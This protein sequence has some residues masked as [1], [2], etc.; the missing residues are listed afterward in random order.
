MEPFVQPTI[1]NSLQ[2]TH[3]SVKELSRVEG[4]KGY[5]FR[6]IYLCLDWRT[7]HS[8]TTELKTG[9][10]GQRTNHNIHLLLETKG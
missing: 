6:T 4:D 9:G 8:N 10:Q 1:I 5:R 7:T 3:K 2:T